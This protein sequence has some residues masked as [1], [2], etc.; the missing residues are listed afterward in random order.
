MLP[1]ALQAPPQP[2]PT[3]AG[4]AAASG[5]VYEETHNGS[6]RRTAKIQFTC[7]LCGATNIK[8]V[9]PHAWRTGTVFAK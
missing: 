7:N 8:P 1:L 9:N 4:G 6:P 5:P 2:G 3:P